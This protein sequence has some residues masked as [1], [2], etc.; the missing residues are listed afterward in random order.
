MRIFKLLKFKFKSQYL[1][2]NLRFLGEDQGETDKKV[3]FLKHFT[4]TSLHS[5]DVFDRSK[6][7]QI[8]GSSQGS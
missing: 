8:H 7:S 4:C 3:V 5:F 1:G 2:T 6:F